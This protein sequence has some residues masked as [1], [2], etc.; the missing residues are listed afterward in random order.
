MDSFPPNK[1]YGPHAY[2]EHGT[3]DCKYRCGCWTGS[4]RSGGPAGLD[5]LNG[6]CPKNPLDGKLLGGN[7]DYEY[8]VT[9]RISDLER[10]AYEAE[11]KLEAVDP[12]KL[13]LAK[14]LHDTKKHLFDLTQFAQQARQALDKAL[15]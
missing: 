8:V 11:R 4:S 3:S 1:E 10:R 5:P 6:K 9:A 14:E 2:E 7:Q 13:V 15:S 12:D